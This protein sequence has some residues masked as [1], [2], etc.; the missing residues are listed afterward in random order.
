MVHRCRKQYAGA[1]GIFAASA[2]FA[3][4]DVNAGKFF[5]RGVCGADVYLRTVVVN[6][7]VKVLKRAAL[8]IF[9]DRGDNLIL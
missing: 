2:A 6:L 7:C 1:A 3:N 4:R 8:N 9:Q 5:A